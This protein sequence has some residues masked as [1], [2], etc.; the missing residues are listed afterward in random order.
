MIFPKIYQ[1]NGCKTETKSTN[2]GQVYLYH[3]LIGE[4]AF[5]FGIRFTDKW[6]R[7]LF[8]LNFVINRKVIPLH[9][10]KVIKYV[11]RSK[12]SLNDFSVKHTLC[13]P[14][15]FWILKYWILH[16][17]QFLSNYLSFFFVFI[18]ALLHEMKIL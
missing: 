14:L 8:V 9:V 17:E 15:I 2:M 13:A 10:P 11:K 6:F 3:E 1:I 12:S 5:E 18:S 4:A 16:F 7:D